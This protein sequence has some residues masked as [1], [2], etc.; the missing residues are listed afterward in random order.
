[1]DIYHIHK[2]GFDFYLKLHKQ[3]IIL[4]RIMYTDVL[5]DMAYKPHL[6]TKEF[7]AKIVVFNNVQSV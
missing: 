1:M 4:S 2:S 6:N 5:A 3:L 7:I